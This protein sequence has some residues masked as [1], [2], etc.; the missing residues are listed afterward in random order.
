MSR[1]EKIFVSVRIKIEA[2]GFL[3]ERRTSL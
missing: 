2:V 3:K 1:L